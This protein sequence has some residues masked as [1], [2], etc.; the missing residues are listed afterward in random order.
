MPDA[1]FETT[2]WSYPDHV[3]ARPTNPASQLTYPM[4]GGTARAGDTRPTV[5]E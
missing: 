4:I 5:Y 2:R 1:G 3:A